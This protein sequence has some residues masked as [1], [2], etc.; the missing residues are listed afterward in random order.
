MREWKPHSYEKLSILG[1][2]LH[3][4]A[5]ATQSAPNRV[6]I[7]AFA[8]DTVNVLA[9]GDQRFPGSAETALS[10]EP[11]FTHMRLFESD[12]RRSQRLQALA[13]A[14]PGRDIRIING[15]CNEL[16]APVLSGLP[17]AA[18]TFA[19]LDPE[20]MELRWSTIR[21]IA[22]HKRAHAQRTGRSKVEMWILFSSAGIVRMLG[23][24][25][26]HAEEAGHPVRVARLYGAWGAWE[27]VWHA[28]LEGRIS[29]G[30]A[31][32]A[33]VFLYMDRLALLGYR[34]LLVRPIATTR[35]ELYAM[36]FATD[37]S[38]G[39]KI[40]RWAQE[41]ERAR[42]DPSRLFEV[43][44]PAQKY[45]DLHTGWRDDFGIELPPWDEL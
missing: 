15:D 26:S 38:A 6:Y 21:Q 11:A 14:H 4:F 23:S 29:P 16:M 20:G 8:G 17:V 37:H 44:E 27:E 40:M 2:Y 30:D 12:Q 1:D 13:D 45:E 9:D 10:T 31:K 35:N 25:R 28:R 43:S 42:P 36:V 22:E 32:R 19:F 5:L 24:N 34:Y 18:P 7:D 33:Y 3:A 41:K 39:S